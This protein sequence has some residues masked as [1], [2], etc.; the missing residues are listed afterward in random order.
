M[1]VLS[2]GIQ[3]AWAKLATVTKRPQ[4]VCEGPLSLRLPAPLPRPGRVGSACCWQT[5]ADPRLSCAW[6]PT[7][8]GAEEGHG[9][10]W[11][12]CE[13]QLGA[14]R[15]TFT[16]ILQAKASGVVTAQA[17]STM[18]F[19]LQS[20]R[21]ERAV[22]RRFPALPCHLRPWDSHLCRQLFL[23]L[24]WTIALK[25]NW[26]LNYTLQW[27]LVSMY[28]CCHCDWDISASKPLKWTEAF[29]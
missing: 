1:C 23:L 28:T 16:D 11:L 13:D 12:A 18:S 5:Q 22:E 6:T 24:F 9:A 3:S 21:R 4:H 7:I 17:E 19:F 26:H 14:D 25:Y 2:G 8:S 29:F 15:I 20:E 10:T 27:F